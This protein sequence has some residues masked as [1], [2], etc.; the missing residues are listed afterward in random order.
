MKLNEQDEDT[1]KEGLNIMLE[2]LSHKYQS[3]P[4]CAH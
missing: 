1:V 4:D 3:L 2:E